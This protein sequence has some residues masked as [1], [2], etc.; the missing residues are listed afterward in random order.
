MRGKF[1]TFEGGEGAG[2]STQVTRL[3]RNLEVAGEPALITR[4]PGGTGFAEQVRA[5]LLNP[6]TAPHSLLSEAL[7]F[8]AARAD[9]VDKLIR[10]ELE[11]GITV[12]CDRFTDSSR[13]YQSFAGGLDARVIEEIDRLV[14]GDLQPDLTFILDIPVEVGLRRAAERRQIADRFEGRTIEFHTLLREGYL[15]IAETF[16]ERCIV[17]N[18]MQSEDDLARAI[19]ANV[20]AHLFKRR[21][22]IKF[23]RLPHGLGLPLPSYARPGDAGMDLCA[24]VPAAVVNNPPTVSPPTV[25][26]PG[27][28]KLIPT[29]FCVE[30]PEGFEGQ[31]RGRSGNGKK[32]IT[33]AQGVGT[34]DSGYRGELGVLLANYGREPFEIKR[35]DR[36]AQLVIAPVAYMKMIE[37]DELSDSVRGAGGF[38]STGT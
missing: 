20:R 14:V 11:N 16:P 23:K 5:F 15:K 3:F 24:A 31:I 32:G 19:Y 12:V 27:D 37:V 4:E 35:G 25:L 33:V 6:G 13:V 18:A 17:M 34:V 1:I 21:R 22:M 28:V 38:G 30:I 9:H 26:L 2:K 36:I 29:G 10:P 7:L 8:Y